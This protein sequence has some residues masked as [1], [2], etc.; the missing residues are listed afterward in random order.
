MGW[1][2]RAYYRMEVYWLAINEFVQNA[3][4]SKLRNP[5]LPEGQ[6]AHVTEI[7]HN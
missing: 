1:P 6:P 7:D 5:T 2:Y 3:A 4:P